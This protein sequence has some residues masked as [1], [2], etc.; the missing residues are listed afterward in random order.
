[1]KHETLGYNTITDAAF[2]PYE[3]FL[4]IGLDGGYQSIVV[5]GSGE[6]NF[7]SFEANPY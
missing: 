1:M 7:D 6:A 5:P 2:V 4:G 3:D